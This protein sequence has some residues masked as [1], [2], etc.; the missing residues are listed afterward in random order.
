M[1]KA[2]RPITR[3]TSQWL[4]CSTADAPIGGMGGWDG[5]EVEASGH[6]GAA[7]RG[8]EG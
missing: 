3:E 6:R 1:P 4:V 8:E 7:T 5:P 2:R